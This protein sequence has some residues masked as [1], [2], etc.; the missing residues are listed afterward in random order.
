MR[1]HH[2]FE[3]TRTTAFA[4][5]FDARTKTTCLQG[6]I[7]SSIFKKGVKGVICIGC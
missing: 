6:C 1:S 5:L 4:L 7:V 2:F 3:H